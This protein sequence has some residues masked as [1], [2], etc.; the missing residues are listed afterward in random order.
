MLLDGEIL[1]TSKPILISN[2]GRAGSLLLEKVKRLCLQWLVLRTLQRN[3]RTL[4]FCEGAQ[5]DEMKKA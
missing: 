4:R 5:T 1:I 3:I 2:G